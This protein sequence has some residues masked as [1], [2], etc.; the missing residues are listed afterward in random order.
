MERK[1][2]LIQLSKLL[3][4]DYYSKKAIGMDNMMEGGA[5]ITLDENNQVK[6][7]EG[8]P[9]KPTRY[10]NIYGTLNAPTPELPEPTDDV[11][12]QVLS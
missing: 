6:I 7:V 3:P 1:A 2:A 8:T 12:G 11:E 4:K 5:V 9:I 10:R